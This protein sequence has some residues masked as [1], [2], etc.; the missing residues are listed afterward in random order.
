MAILLLRKLISSNY[1]VSSEARVRH[2][3]PHETKAIEFF[4]VMML[5]SKAQER[6]LA[7][8][9]GHSLKMSPLSSQYSSILFIQQIMK[10]DV[11]NHRH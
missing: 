7:K 6:R 8:P 5:P 2:V 1:L 9:E 4:L 3:V 11:A 10:N